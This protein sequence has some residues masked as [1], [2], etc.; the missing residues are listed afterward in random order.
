MSKKA[1]REVSEVIQHQRTENPKIV[2]EEGILFG[3]AMP[4]CRNATTLEAQG[5]LRFK[6]ARGSYGLTRKTKDLV[7][8]IYYITDFP[9]DSLAEHQ[10]YS[11]ARFGSSREYAVQVSLSYGEFG[12]R[13][14]LRGFDAFSKPA[15]YVRWR[16]DST[17]AK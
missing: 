11:L 6:G 7:E 14:F 16:L 4:S 12:G 8:T 13:L 15:P 10:G 9:P 17:E 2:S 5:W 1:R 3:R